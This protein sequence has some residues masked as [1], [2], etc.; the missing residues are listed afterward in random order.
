MLS[1]L[2]IRFRSL[3]RRATVEHELDDELRSHVDQQVERY[4]R[5]RMCRKEALRRVRLEFGGIEQVR[6]DCRDAR[7][8]SFFKS[9]A[10]DLRYAVRQMRQSPAFTLLTMLIMTLGIGINT[11]IFSLVYHVLLEPLSFPQAN[12]LFAIW[13]RSDA[14]G[15]ARIASSGL[16]FL[17]YHDHTKSCRPASAGAPTIRSGFLCRWIPPT[18]LPST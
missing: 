13:A 6:E 1:D 9:L 18:K 14:E 17:D 16:D 2:R 8:V 11:T 7:G 12:H 4:M 15:N 3:F 10:Q 5:A